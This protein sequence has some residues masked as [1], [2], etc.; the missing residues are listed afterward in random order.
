MKG[1]DSKELIHGT[2]DDDNDDDDDDDDD[3]ND[4]VH[5]D[6]HGAILQVSICFASAATE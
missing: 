6:R 3:D 2:E 4:D 1:V 5:L